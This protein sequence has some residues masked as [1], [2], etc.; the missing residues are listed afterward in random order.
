MSENAR[1]PVAIRIV[2]PYDSEAEFLE[3]ELETVGKTSVILIGAHSRPQGVILRFEVVLQNG[4]VVLRGEGR[5]LQHKESAFRGQAGLALRF[6]RLDPK[7]KAVVDRAS[8]LREARLSGS[9]PPQAVPVPPEASSSP[10]AVPDAEPTPLPPTRPPLSRP[11]PKMPSPRI[12]SRP[13]TQPPPA[14]SETPPGPLVAI[15]SFAPMKVPSN[16]PSSLPSGMPSAAPAPPNATLAPDPMLAQILTANTPPPPPVET[17]TEAPPPGD[18]M[19]EEMSREEAK[20]RP[21]KIAQLIEEQ[22]V[23]HAH[24]TTTVA[25]PANQAE[26]PPPVVAPAPKA[27]NPSDAPSNTAVTKVADRDALLARLRERRASMS[28]DERNAILNKQR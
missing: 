21:G 12:E 6:T 11:P 14:S 25:A 18:G 4:A 22:A 7:S 26:P 28:D 24:S 3:S 10:I 27:P 5:V 2:R 9:M 15:P 13:P 17:K 16:I 20:T 19:E 1:P 23:A 8:A